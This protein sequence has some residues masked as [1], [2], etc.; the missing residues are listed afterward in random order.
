LETE[1]INNPIQQDLEMVDIRD[2]DGDG[3]AVDA[4]NPRVNDDEDGDA[5]AF[6][7]EEAFND[8]KKRSKVSCGGH[9]K[10]GLSKMH[11]R[12]GSR[13][14]IGCL[15]AVLLPAFMLFF[16]SSHTTVIKLSQSE[17]LNITL[18]HCDLD[19]ETGP[20]LE[21]HVPIFNSAARF[22]DISVQIRESYRRFMPVL[23][24]D[25]AYSRTANS[26]TAKAASDGTSYLK[27]TFDGNTVSVKQPG[28]YTPMFCRN[29]PKQCNPC[30]VKLRVP[31]G[32]LLP[33]F[34][35]RSEGQAPAM[36][37]SKVGLKASGD[38][39]VS[40]AVHIR[41]P[42]LKATS[43]NISLDAGSVSLQNLD[44]KEYTSI[45]S[46]DDVILQSKV[47]IKLNFTASNACLGAPFRHMG[48][49]SC[50]DQI[51][52]LN[53]SA[54][55]ESSNMTNSNSSSQA[56]CSGH[57]ALCTS[58][59]QECGGTQLQKVSVVASTLHVR[60]YQHYEEEKANRRGFF[61]STA[62]YLPLA[63]P[64]RRGPRQLEVSH[65]S[66][67]VPAQCQ[68]TEHCV[69]QILHILHA[70]TGAETSQGKAACNVC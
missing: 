41:I 68:S 11:F 60:V 37:Q 58:G 61:N 57:I 50:R 32:G 10:T 69:D 52:G 49:W 54:I 53:F 45:R 35:L 29:N 22:S 25:D 40:G 31:P 39:T 46:R 3:E 62:P 34:S 51:P 5:D 17:P 59:S 43:V 18:Q 16:V 67:Q 36:F 19:V 55:T 65:N 66:L 63:I 2:G 64:P 12:V 70:T 30:T 1:T 56:I 6:N 44:V 48:N 47:S 28:M 23:T 7:D 8:E 15:V 21:I 42:S 26:S 4:F 20:D 38:F 27:L 24:A 9:H 14:L 33:A 13:I